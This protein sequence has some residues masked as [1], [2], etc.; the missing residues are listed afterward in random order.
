MTGRP[1]GEVRRQP[2]G[3]ARGDVGIDRF[4]GGRSTVVDQAAIEAD[5]R[6]DGRQA[7][8]GGDAACVD[9]DAQPLRSTT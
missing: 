8:F 7:E 2:G 1:V 5:R 3:E 4:I 9:R 6:A